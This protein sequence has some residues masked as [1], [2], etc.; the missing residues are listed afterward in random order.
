MG[1]LSDR[2]EIVYAPSAAVYQYCSRRGERATGAGAVFGVPDAGVPQIADESRQVAQRLGT[3]RL[4][5]GADATLDKL[6]SVAADARILHIA[7]HGVFNRSQ[8]MLSAIRLAEDWV[9]LYDLYSLDI[10]GE[11]VVL[12]TCES[13]TAGV[14][15]GNE[16]LGLTRG[17]LYAGAPALLCSQWR[18]RDGV[19][20]EFMSAFYENLAVLPDAAAAQQAA[21]A[22]VRRKYPHPYHWAPF[23]LTGRPVTKG[24]ASPISASCE[25]R[26]LALTAAN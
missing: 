6:R 4:Y 19:A 13:G 1:W 26:E 15:A 16:I 22:T 8:P 9:T 21:M 10:R 17:C 23:F 3:E 2:F 25:S 12:S 5:L 24:A 18:V 14:T 7:T 11:L 20:A